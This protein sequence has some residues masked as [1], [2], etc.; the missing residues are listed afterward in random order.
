MEC[1]KFIYKSTS[2]RLPFTLLTITT[3]WD[4]DDKKNLPAE[5]NNFNGMEVMLRTMISNHHH[6]SPS[7]SSSSSSLS[8]FVS[9]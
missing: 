4:A 3:S 9:A 1:K 5:R 2:I 8:S 6:N 7:A